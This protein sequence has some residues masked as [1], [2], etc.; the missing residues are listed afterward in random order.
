M[1]SS[2]QFSCSVVSSALQPHGLQHP[3]LQSGRDVKNHAWVEDPLKV[4]GKWMDFNVT[5]S[6]KFSDM[7][8][9]Y[10]LQLPF[11]E[12]WCNNQ[13]NFQLPGY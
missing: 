5:E 10:T 13:Q 6:E 12:C 8:S 7:V 3:K 11:V 4:Q 2:A 9:G 1:L